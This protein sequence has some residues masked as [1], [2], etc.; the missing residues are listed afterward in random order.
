MINY[1]L[2]IGDVESNVR[3]T[4]INMNIKVLVWKQGTWEH[5]KP[6]LNLT[7]TQWPFRHFILH[8]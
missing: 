4:R 6:F 1:L 8:Y 3:Q 2:S 5:R 7:T